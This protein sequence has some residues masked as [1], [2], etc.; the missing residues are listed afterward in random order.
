MTTGGQH[1][2]THRHED[3]GDDKVDDD[4]GQEDQKADFEGAPQLTDHEGGDED[5]QAEIFRCFGRFL[6]GHVE[7][8]RKILLPDMLAHEHVEGRC[9]QLERFGRLNF[10]RDQRLDARIVGFLKGWSHDEGCQ[11]QG[12]ADHHRVR[13]SGLKPD[14]RAQQG[15]DHHDPGERCHHDQDRGGEREDRDQGDQL[16][17]PLGDRQVIAKADAQLLS[18]CLVIEYKAQ[19]EHADGRDKHERE[20]AQQ[21][22]PRVP[23]FRCLSRGH[24][25]GL[26]LDRGDDHR[27]LS[28]ES[29]LRRR[30]I[31]SS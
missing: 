6:L 28:P 4:E 9:R 3:R 11:K 16:H 17:R 5:A 25:L 1:H 14:G 10:P 29:S 22:V 20:T 27:L 15:Q 12:K 7:K 21:P 31:S 13:G 8:Q 18:Q 2:H 30:L 26:R 24:V 23:S 19:K